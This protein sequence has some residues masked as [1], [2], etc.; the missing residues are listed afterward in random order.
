LFIDTAT[1]SQTRLKDLRFL[2]P[3]DIMPNSTITCHCGAVN[4]N[5]LLQLP[6]TSELCH[7]NPCRQTS[8]GLYEGFVPLTQPPPASALEHCTVYPSRHDHDRYFCTTCGTKTFIRVHRSG[9]EEYWTCISGAVDPPKGTENVLKIE[10]NKWVSDTGDG[11]LAPFM[12]ELGGRQ[13]VS[14]EEAEREGKELTSSDLM[15]MTESANS[16]PPLSKDAMLTAECRCGGVSLRIKRADH[17][18]PSIPMPERYIPA[19]K[20]KYVGRACVCRDCRLHQGVSLAHWLYLPYASVINPHTN[21][22]VAHRAAATMPE[23]Q[24]ANKGLNLTH[25]LGSAERGA[26]RAFCSTCGASVLYDFDDRPHITNIAAGL[27]RAEEGVMARRWVSWEWGGTSWKE[28]YV[29]REIRDA[30]MAT[31]ESG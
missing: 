24:A 18:D 15:K 4:F 23:G 19:D 7:C 30:W 12:T 11:G 31:A 26:Y 25:Y 13:I 3:I 9:E 28:N 29:D 2:K 21:Q 8:G 6:A 17:T 1:E 10:T 27:I 16:L 22:P 5:V 20:T 14:Y